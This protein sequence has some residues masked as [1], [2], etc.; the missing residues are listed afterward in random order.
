MQGTLRLWMT[1]VVAPIARAKALSRSFCA[2]CVYGPPTLVLSSSHLGTFRQWPRTG[3]LAA[4]TVQTADV[5]GLFP[6]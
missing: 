4:P 1:A 3:V 2:P 5:L 6:V